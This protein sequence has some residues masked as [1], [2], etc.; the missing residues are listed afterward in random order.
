LKLLRKAISGQPQE[1]PAVE[2]Q[3]FDGDADNGA[4][5]EHE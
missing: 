2:G 3:V 5:F 4:T 1:R